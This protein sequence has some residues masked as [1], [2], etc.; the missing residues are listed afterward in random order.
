[1]RNFEEVIESAF[2]IRG[3][4]RPWL[5]LPGLHLCAQLFCKFLFKSEGIEGAL[6]NFFDGRTLL[7]GPDRGGVAQ[8]NKIAV[9]AT[10]DEREQPV[11]LTSYNRQWRAKDEERKCQGRKLPK[12]SLE[13]TREK[14]TFYGGKKRLTWN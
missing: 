13:L 3:I 10:G 9:V 14:E 1:M 2:S 5:E 4:W 12:V 7:F 11:L 6:R 8:S